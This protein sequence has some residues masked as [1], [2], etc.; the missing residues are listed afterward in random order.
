M[1][2]TILEISGNVTKIKA[3]EYRGQNMQHVKISAKI[4]EIGH[5]SFKR[6]LFL[7]TVILPDGLE[8][9]WSEAFAECNTLKRISIPNSVKKISIGAF[10]K[11]ES[12]ESI[13]FPDE[14]SLHL[15]GT[16]L[17]RCYSLTHI[18]LPISLLASCKNILTIMNDDS[19]YS[20]KSI[21][22]RL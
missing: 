19:R 13:R 6:C 2:E 5:K 1:T 17:K 15:P 18:S 4:K 7:Q 9:I 16:I 10:Y 22:I 21:E 14:V 8:T 11:C 20:L 12:L 3:H